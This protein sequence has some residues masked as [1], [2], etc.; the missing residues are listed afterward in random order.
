MTSYRALRGMIADERRDIVATLRTLSDEEWSAPSLCAGW[1][2]RDVVAHLAS[3]ASALTYA[4]TTVRQGFSPDRVNNALVRRHRAL[5]RAQLTDLLEDTAGRGMLATTLPGIMLADAVVH[6]QDIL[7]PLGRTRR[8]PPERLRHAI[9]HPDPFAYP[10]RRTRGLRF[11]ATDLDWSS[12]SGPEVRGTGE[13]LALAIA[14]R[15]VVLDEL[16]GDGVPVLRARM[17]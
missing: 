1:Q 3:D 13:A 7:R 4:A 14:G 15:P 2:V 16:D 9:A 17:E 8:I 11:V 12:G 10:G 5:P 6:H